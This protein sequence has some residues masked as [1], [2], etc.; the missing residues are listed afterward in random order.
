M[1]LVEPPPKT[2]TA[3]E[4][5]ELPDDG[6]ERD[7]IRGE[8]RKRPFLLRTPNH[9][10]ALTSIGHGLSLWVEQQ[11]GPRGRVA[12]GDVGCRLSR[13]PETFVGIDVAY[14]SAEMVARRDR[15]LRFYDGPPVLA[16]EILSPSDQHEDVVEKVKLY[17]EV[18]T[19]VWVVDPDF[20]TVRVHRAGQP[21][22]LYNDGQELL[23]EPE[24][25]GFRVAV[26][27]L[28]GD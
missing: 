7:I 23:G 4:L 19:V 6:V 13:D 18:G 26:S 11:P 3:E 10:E 17:L 22:V 25:T 21:V 14:V 2:M 9:G 27:R 12:C 20:R 1:S 24:L 15:K 5:M 8:L 16:V 28:F